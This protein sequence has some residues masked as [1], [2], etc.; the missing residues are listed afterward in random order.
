MRHNPL[1]P[2]ATIENFYRSGIASIHRYRPFRMLA[3]VLDKLEYPAGAGARAAFRP[4]R[5]DLRRHAADAV[6]R[7]QAARGDARRPAGQRGSRFIGFTAEGERTLDW[8]R[9]IVGDARA[10][11]AGDQGAQATASPASLRIAAIPTALAMVARLTT[12]YRARHPECAL[13]HPV[14]HLDRDPRRSS[15]ISR[16]M[17]ASPISTTSRSAASTPCRSI[18]ERY[19]LLTSPDAPL[20]DREQRHL[21]RGRAGAAL[22]AHA[23]HAEPPHHRRP[24][25]R[26][27]RQSAADAG[28]QLDDRAVR[29]CAHRPLGE[30]DAGASSPRRWA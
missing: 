22:P 2:I 20:G 25:A 13:H 8:A 23:R 14:A 4:R 5:R 27:R 9:R 28:I 1:S 24:A 26:R 21:G 11:R 16:S 12:P 18:S 19:R 30:R 7:H 6:G 15:K 29:A 10:M 17:P 3:P